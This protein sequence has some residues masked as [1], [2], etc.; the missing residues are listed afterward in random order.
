MVGAG[1]FCTLYGE[2]GVPIVGQLV[3]REIVRG[4][5][6]TGA[7]NTTRSKFTT[8]RSKNTTA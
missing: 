6:M 4:R 2:T 1:G 3:Q 5:E 7:K 8:R